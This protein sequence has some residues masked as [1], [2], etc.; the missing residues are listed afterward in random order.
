M[1]GALAAASFSTPLAI[2]HNSL[3]PLL[4]Q[5][6]YSSGLHTACSRRVRRTILIQRNYT[7][8]SR[9]N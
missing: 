1:C 3:G 6:V 4:C 9:F 8:K 5:L 7:A 2:V